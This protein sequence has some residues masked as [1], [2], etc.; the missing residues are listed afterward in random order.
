MNQHFPRSS[1]ILEEHCL[2]PYFGKNQDKGGCL[3]EEM[4]NG[5]FFAAPSKLRQ[6]QG[7]KAA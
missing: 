2:R 7:S 6:K 5:R 1:I 3:F 4:N